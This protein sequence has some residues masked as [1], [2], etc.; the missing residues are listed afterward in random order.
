MA[1]PEVVLRCNGQTGPSKSRSSKRRR[2]PPLPLPLPPPLPPAPPPPPLELV[3]AYLS[4]AAD[5]DMEQI[6]GFVTN[7]SNKVGKSSRR[8]TYLCN[9]SIENNNDDDNDRVQPRKTKKTRSAITI[10]QFKRLHPSLQ[11][12]KDEGG[13][14]QAVVAMEYAND[15]ATNKP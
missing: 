4:A 11:E 5:D 10:N 2:L 8:R 13:G 7:N 9:Q 3:A 1:L 14:G 15:G 6:Y 12:S